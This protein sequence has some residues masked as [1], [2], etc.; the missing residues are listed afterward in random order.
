MQKETTQMES[1]KRPDTMARINTPALA[2]A[3]IDEQLAVLRRQIG[4]K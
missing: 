3:F 1:N 4:D 2:Q